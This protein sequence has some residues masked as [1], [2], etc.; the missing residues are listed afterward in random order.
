VK[1]LWPAAEEVT[2]AGTLGDL[3]PGEFFYFQ[4]HPKVLC[5]RGCDEVYRS[6]IGPNG[7]RFVQFGDLHGDNR[8]VALNGYGP[9]L[10]VRRVKAAIVELP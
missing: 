5:L 9:V 4:N 2:P 10:I 7:V 6:R 8:E 1:Q 3:K